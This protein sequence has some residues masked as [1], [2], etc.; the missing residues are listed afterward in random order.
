M[1]I[2]TSFEG[3]SLETVEPIPGVH[4]PPDWDVAANMK[5]LFPFSHFPL[6]WGKYPE[7]FLTMKPQEPAQQAPPDEDDPELLRNAIMDEWLLNRVNELKEI[8]ERLARARKCE[9][10][11]AAVMI[12]GL[13]FDLASK[14]RKAQEEYNDF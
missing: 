4:L 9:P 3:R 1:P 10:P 14:I 8:E 5:R 6:L 13:L 11:E 12:D 2:L 7:V